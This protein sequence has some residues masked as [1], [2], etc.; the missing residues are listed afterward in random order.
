MRSSMSM[1]DTGGKTNRKRIE[2]SG[3]AL[4]LGHD[5]EHHLASD[6]TEADSGDK[7]STD[8][9]EDSHEITSCKTTQN[10]SKRGETYSPS[11]LMSMVEK[12]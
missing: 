2:L 9:K 4:A 7:C 12:H 6:S 10:G 5:P 11:N 3:L 8:G 1:R